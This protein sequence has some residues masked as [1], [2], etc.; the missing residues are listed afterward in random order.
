M[1][2]RIVKFV[3]LTLVVMITLGVMASCTM[4]GLNYASLETANK[5]D[6]R[7]ELSVS[8]LENWLDDRGQLLSEFQDLVYGPWPEDLPVALISRRVADD[9]F[10]GGRARLEEL[11]IR[12]GEGEASEDFFLGLAVPHNV[13]PSGLG[14]V[15]GQT[16]SDNCGV[17]QSLALSKSSGQ[18]CTSTNVPWI[19]EYIFGEY[20]AEVPFDRYFDAGFAY[21]SYYASDV[22]PDRV[23]AGRAAMDRLSNG[24]DRAPTGTLMAWAYA[25]KAAID[26]LQDDLW[27]DEDRIAVYGHSRHGKS[28]LLGGIFDPR[29]DLV[30]SHQSGFGGAALSRST[31]GEG[32]ERVV[33]TYPHWFAPEFEALSKDPEALP[34][35]QHQLL[36]LLAPTPVFLGNGRRDVWS[37]PNSTY[38]AAESASRI[39]QLYGRRGLSQ[40][41]LIDYD[42]AGDLAYFLRPGGHGTDQRDIAGILAFLES[43]TR[44]GDAAPSAMASP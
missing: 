17:F 38:R 41:G 27:L 12:L 33:D 6:P 34:V 1:F 30:I 29:I 2:L 4:L 25:Y 31:V 40:Q 28:A 5:P 26:V 9:A 36:A 13:P 43:H 44:K 7:P 42:P 15:I 20:I 21:A 18:A 35:D 16:F 39:Y 10:A 11:R 8:S 3:V 14:L 19:V 32:I 23:E 22:V 37:D 24:T